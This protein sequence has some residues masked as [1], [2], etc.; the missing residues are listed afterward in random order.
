MLTFQ[1]EMPEHDI[2]VS[3]SLVVKKCTTVTDQPYMYVGVWRLSGTTGNWFKT[4]LFKEDIIA[5]QDIY[6]HVLVAAEQK[7]EISR[8]ISPSKRIGT[9]LFKG[10]MYINIT[11]MDRATKERRGGFNIKSDEIF[12][13][14]DMLEMVN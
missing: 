7:E 13:I 14:A 1:M 6:P 4:C 12:P 11:V 5:L 8:D 10:V 2:Q 3:E 9:K